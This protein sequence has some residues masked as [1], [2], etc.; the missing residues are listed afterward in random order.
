MA[1]DS[2]HHP[3]FEALRPAVDFARRAASRTRSRLARLSPAAFARTA[4]WA[5]A[6]LRA[7]GVPVPIAAVG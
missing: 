4:R 1:D 7:V 6:V 3:A 5:A 2:R